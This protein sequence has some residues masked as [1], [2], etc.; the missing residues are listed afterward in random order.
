V[1]D[2]A[3]VTTSAPARTARLGGGRLLVSAVVAQ[4]TVSIAEMG[5]PTIGPLIKEIFGLTTVG[6]G[7]LVAAI[8]MGR[9]GGA[10]P[11]G[12]LADRFGE[13][14]AF[15]VGGF[16]LALAMG[17]AAGAWSATALLGALFVCGIFAS[18][19]TPAG[20]RLVSR[21]IARGHVGLALG[22]RQAAVPVG[23]LTAALILP[24]LAT[25]YGVRM[26][27][28]V[29]GIFPAVGALIAFLGVRH[30]ERP[31]RRPHRERLLGVLGAPELR[32]AVAWAV[33]F[34]SGQY[35]IVTF[36][37]LSLKAEMGFSLGLAVAML[38]LAQVGGIVGRICWGMLSDTASG[39]PRAVLI[40]IS[41]VGTASACL[42]AAAPLWPS[43]VF[44]GIVSFLIGTTLIGWQ[45]AWMKL[46]ADLSPPHR[47]GTTVGSGLAFQGIGQVAWPPLLGLVAV[48]SGGFVAL[49]LTLAAILACSSVLLMRF[50]AVER[51][52]QAERDLR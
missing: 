33:L 37:V 39:G 44:L 52:I 9:I 5:V 40:A 30:H 35:A 32:A 10:F 1:S 21:T 50:G 48:L 41:I 26:A 29:A 51:D 17:A 28:L 43:A 12:R 45:G 20:A 22:L 25:A 36:L 13:A 38:I 46:L 42:L 49:W 23:G 18:S 7:L 24:P 27:L 11:S 34:I 8:N 6:V 31:R 16:G 47:M 19:A 2:S 15:L 4:A 14:S 3:P